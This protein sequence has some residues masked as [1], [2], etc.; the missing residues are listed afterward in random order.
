MPITVGPSEGSTRVTSAINA[1]AA[2]TGVD[3]GYLLNQARIESGLRPDAQAAT[4]SASGLFQFTRQTW[5]A[6]VKQHGANHG[7]AWAADAIRQSPGGAY[8]VSDPRLRAAIL[9][10]RNEPEAA[11]NMAAEFASD[12]ADFLGARLDR[13]AQ[14]VDLYLAH[15]LGTG[16][17]TQFLKAHDTNP[18]LAAAPLFPAAARA[19][20]AIFYDKTGRARSLG[21]IRAHFAGKLGAD[22]GERP[23]A[24]A[25]MVVTAGALPFSAANPDIRAKPVAAREFPQVR[26][27]EPMPEHL[28]LDFAKHAYLRLASMG[29]G[30]R[31]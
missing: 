29:G 21:E 13:P 31:S 6:T 17:A 9:N 30:A 11:A 22:V 5:L 25:P 24:F 18:D 4:S 8:H 23:G 16:G 27:I 3:F 28:S 7:L 2:K 1:A 20:R 15:F 14:S 19:N 12:N 10:L 26:S